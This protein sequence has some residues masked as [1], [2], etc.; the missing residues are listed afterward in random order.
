MI[1]PPSPNGLS[2]LNCVRLVSPL[3]TLMSVT[4]VLWATSR[5]RFVSPLSGLKSVIGELGSKGV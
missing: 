3:S 5:S 1:K 4:K 2:K